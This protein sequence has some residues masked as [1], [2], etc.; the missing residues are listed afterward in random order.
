[1]AGRG[2]HFSIVTVQRSGTHFLTD[3]LFAGW[4][5]C[6]VNQASDGNGFYLA[7]FSDAEY[8]HRR[9]E[10]LCW[11]MVTSLR[12]PSALVA[13]HHSRREGCPFLWK[14]LDALLEADREVKIN[15]LPLDVP[16]REEYLN[17][18]NNRYSL[19]LSTDWPIIRSDPIPKKIEDHRA[20]RKVW[21]HYGELFGRFYER[22]GD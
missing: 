5:R 18:L 21:E 22:P 6:A 17:R 3:E 14:E 4:K 8:I 9:S 12:N 15:Y 13:S 1:M 10:I 19:A 7:H 20:T 16:D 11:P 2:C